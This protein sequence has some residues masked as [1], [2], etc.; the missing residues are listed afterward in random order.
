ADALGNRVDDRR[1]Y[2]DL[3]DGADRALAGRVREPLELEDALRHDG[4]GVE[5][6]VH[7]RR[8]GVVGTAVDDDV[9]VD[10]ARDPVHDPDPVAGVLEDAR[11]LDV[12]LDPA[13]EV[14]QDV[15]RLAPAPRLVAGRYGVL[16]EAPPVVERAEALLQLLFRDALRHD[17]A[18]EQHLAEPGALLLEERDQLQRQVEP[19]LLVEPAD[20]ECGHDPESAVE[21]AP[22]AVRVAVRADAERRL[23]PWNVPGYQCA[24]RVLVDLEADLLER[25]REVVERV[26]VDLRVGVP[27]DRFGRLCVVGPAERLDV[28]RNPLAAA[29]AFDRDHPGHPSRIVWWST[30]AGG[31]ARR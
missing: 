7:R 10:V 9:G 17:P 24:D 20:F 25:T 11:L 30:R 5:P 18:A 29:A 28:A 27:P 21:A 8:A 3:A 31:T 26:A 6:E 12:H 16:P 23:A 15:D 1:M 2:V 19:E 4:A 13:G 14:V 22:V